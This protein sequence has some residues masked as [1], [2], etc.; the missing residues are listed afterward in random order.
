[1][2]KLRECPNPWCEKSDPR[3]RRYCG[4]EDIYWV[5]CESCCL[6]AGEFRTKTDAIADWNRR[7]LNPREAELERVLREAVKVLVAFIAQGTD[8]YEH[9][10]VTFDFEL[11]AQLQAE[12]RTAFGAARE[13][14]GEGK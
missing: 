10:C 9:Q 14:L 11:A 4:A 7:P 8:D 6:N 2:E 5:G 13:V 12:A 3:L 1:M